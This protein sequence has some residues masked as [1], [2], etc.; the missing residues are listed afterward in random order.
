MSAGRGLLTLNVG[1][2]TVKAAYYR[3]TAEGLAPDPAV[4]AKIAVLPD[5]DGDAR[6]GDRWL[7]QLLVRLPAGAGQPDAV[8]HRVVHGGAR[9]GPATV[10]DAL[11][12]E[13]SA[14][15]PLAPLHQKPALRLMDAARSRWP[16]VPQVAA[17]DTSWHA[18]LAQWTRRLPV[19]E[20]LHAA[21]V[22]RYGFHGLAFASALRQLKELEPAMAQARVVLAHLGGGS[23]LCAMVQGRSV[24]TTM[25]MTPLD[26]LPMAT[27]SG[28]LDP[29]VVLYLAQTLHMPL[30][31][32]EH[33]LWRE[34]GLRGLSGGSGDMR[35]LLADP[36]EPAALAREHYAM[37]IAQGIAA[38]TTS[39]GGVD[40][41]VF[42]GGI[43]DGAAP[44]RAQV[45]E[46]LRWI[47]L[48]LDPEANATGAA[49]IHVANSTVA[50]FV[51]RADEERELA[52][53][54]L[55]E[56]SP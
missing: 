3:L 38:M 54:L 17:F 8:A 33:L 13:L 31:Q 56:W 16:G 6:S 15:T 14:L 47:G 40:A 19:P 55:E 44:I 30:P 22:M 25:G 51:F 36:S 5:D 27:R 48:H 34:S 2:A 9:A 39:L 53:A 7:S 45:A 43:G 46:Q 37:R 4:R 21:G 23:S 10:T 35:E 42:S 50:A 49:R 1:S 41:I 29:G 11:M 18:T 32:I 52:L 24:D 28:A 26:G 12:G 20:R